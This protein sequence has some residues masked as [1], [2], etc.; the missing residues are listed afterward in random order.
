MAVKNKGLGK[1]LGA[2]LGAEAEIE[3]RRNP[4]K[5]AEKKDESGE[6]LVKIRLI[7][8]NRTQPRKNCRNLRIRSASTA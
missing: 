1:G 3:T 6:I 5:P 7:E 4:T 2:L 8:P